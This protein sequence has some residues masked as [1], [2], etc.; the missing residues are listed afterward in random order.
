[1]G[2]YFDS[3]IKWDN[4]KDRAI[5]FSFFFFLLDHLQP[6]C[7]LALRPVSWPYTPG[8][9]SLSHQRQTVCLPSMCQS[10]K[11]KNL[12][13]KYINNN[14]DDKMKHWAFP[15]NDECHPFTFSNKFQVNFHI[16]P[17]PVTSRFQHVTKYWSKLVISIF[18][19]RGYNPCSWWSNANACINMPMNFWKRLLFLNHP[20][21]PVCLFETLEMGTFVWSMWTFQS[22]PRKKCESSE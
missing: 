11:S 22:M 2:T 3:G 8:F 18:L 9:G 21:G 13:N 20:P 15:M 10:A 6:V 14:N 17:H 12:N 1:M 7:E 4:H 5:E 19:C 16:Y